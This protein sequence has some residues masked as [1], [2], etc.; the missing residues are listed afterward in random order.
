MEQWLPI[1]RDPVRRAGG[2]AGFMGLVARLHERLGGACALLGYLLICVGT[3]VMLVNADSLN[4]VVGGS[5]RHR[6]PLWVFA[7]LV[8]GGPII[9]GIAI[10]VQ[11]ARQR[12]AQSGSRDAQTPDSE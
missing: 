8:Y 11:R 2:V 4:Q 6:T 5:G 7:I 1:V 3:A 10:L 9:G 12:R